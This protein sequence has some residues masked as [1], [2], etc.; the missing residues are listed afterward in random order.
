MIRCHMGLLP[1]KRDEE[2][3]GEKFFAFFHIFW[4]VLIG[5]GLLGGS[6]ISCKL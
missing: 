6:F 3:R 4:I 1:V 5:W 2:G